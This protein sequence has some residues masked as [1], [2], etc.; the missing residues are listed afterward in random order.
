MTSLWKQHIER[1][2]NTG[3]ELDSLPKGERKAIGKEMRGFWKLATKADTSESTSSFT[4]LYDKDSVLSLGYLTQTRLVKFLQSEA[5]ATMVGV[6]CS[7][8]GNMQREMFVRRICAEFFE[9]CIPSNALKDKNEDSEDEAYENVGNARSM[10]P[11]KFCLFRGFYNTLKSA[12]F[13]KKRR[14]WKRENVP[15]QATNVVDLDEPEPVEAPPPPA[16]PPPSPEPEQEVPAPPSSPAPEQEVPAPPPSPA[17]EKDAPAPPP[18]PT[19]APA[20]ATP[21]APEAAPAPKKRKRDPTADA[22]TEVKDGTLCRKLIDV[23]SE[24]KRCAK[25]DLLV[26]DSTSSC[27]IG[28]YSDYRVVVKQRTMGKSALKCDAYVF[29]TGE[30]RRISGQWQLRSIPE[31]ARHFNFFSALNTNI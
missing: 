15:Y 9:M 14:Q 8:A 24:G 30:S 13:Q 29:V 31:M 4:H 26:F 25:N 6:D 19:A 2:G 7:K 11:G 27:V 1:Q 12:R 16:P 21:P 18:S 3:I 10:R 23:F 5:G 20:P 22:S 17:P 28:S